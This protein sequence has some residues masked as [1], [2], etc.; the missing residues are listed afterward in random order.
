MVKTISIINQKGGSGKTTSTVSIAASLGEVG[1]K[2]LVIDVDAQ[3]S[4]T[5]WLGVRDAGKGIYT[6]FAEGESLTNLIFETDTSGVDVIPSSS[7][8]AMAEKAVLLNE[9][10][11]ISDSPNTILERAMKKLPTEW[12]FVLFDCPPALGIQSKNALVASNFVLVPVAAEYMAL[13][14]IAELRKTIQRTQEGLNPRLKVLGV[15]ACRFDGRT[16]HAHEVVEALKENFGDLFFDTVIR[17]NV[18]IAEAPS[19]AQ[20]ITQY[21]TNSAGAQDYRKL[22]REIL[23]RLESQSFKRTANL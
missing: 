19:F 13:Q 10:Q 1:K 3:A 16:N 20:P 23:S 7:W 4:A 5:S 9:D 14:G 22:T 11:I 2:V 8:L 6:V 18:R 12:D 21:D 17:E 15:F